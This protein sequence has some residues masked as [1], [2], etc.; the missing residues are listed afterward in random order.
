MIVLLV[1]LTGGIGSGK[2]TV[3]RMLEERGAVILDADAF[4][5]DAVRAG[6]EGFGQVVERFG[7][8][9]VGPDGELDRPKLASIV[10]SDPEAL[11]DL[12]SIVHP[13]VRRMTA[14]AIQANLDL[15]RVVVLVNPLLIEMGTHRDCDVVVVVSVS[16]LAQVARSVARGMQEDDVRARIAAQR[17]LEERARQADVLI[18]NEGSL[19]E[20]AAQVEQLW[21][22]LDADAHTGS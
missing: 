15:E 6:S 22:R 18:D 14:D 16:P 1:G 5:R 17:P 20:L 2:S 10:F 12:E 7:K 8:E 3:A 4:A 21:A 19:D 13:P 9:I 11:G